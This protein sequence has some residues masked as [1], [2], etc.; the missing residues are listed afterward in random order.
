M[1][2]QGLSTR[3]LQGLLGHVSPVTTARYARLTE[4]TEQESAA[5]MN[6]VVNSLRVELRR[7]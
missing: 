3:H 5:V 1:L 7:R 4:I 6:R 2:E